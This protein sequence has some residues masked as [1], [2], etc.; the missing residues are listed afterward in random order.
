MTIRLEMLA[1]VNQELEEKLV[2]FESTNQTK[3]KLSKF[4]STRQT[5]ESSFVQVELINNEDSVGRNSCLEL[6]WL[7]F[8][9]QELLI[10]AQK[11]LLV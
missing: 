8:R 3:E 7:S 4:E 5:K 11:A 2:K 1:K 10:Q 9:I 6:D